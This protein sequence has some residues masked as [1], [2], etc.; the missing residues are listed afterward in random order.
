MIRF[1][2]GLLL[3]I[4]HVCKAGTITA[5]LATGSQTLSTET[6]YTFTMELETALSTS[7]HFIFDFDSNLGVQ[8]PGSLSTCTG[9]VGFTTTSIPCIKLTEN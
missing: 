6:S 9:V 5:S 1:I 3:I 2:I 4:T 7:N 8:I